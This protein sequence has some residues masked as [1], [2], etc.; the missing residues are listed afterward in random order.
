MS[1]VSVSYIH[2]CVCVQ[3]IWD[4]C[5]LSAV[6]QLHGNQSGGRL[7]WGQVDACGVPVIMRR[8]QSMWPVGGGGGGGAFNPP[9]HYSQAALPSCSRNM[10]VLSYPLSLCTLQDQFIFKRWKCEI[11]SL[12]FFKN[13]DVLPESGLACCKV[14]GSPLCDLQGNRKRGLSPSFLDWCHFSWKWSAIMYY[15]I[16][17][18]PIGL[19]SRRNVFLRSLVLVLICICTD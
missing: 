2:T 11:K 15:C 6:D 17:A 9:P 18:A 10:S 3:L 19:V 16:I 5:V 12:Y 14:T 7:K 1:R 4:L 13:D 8:K